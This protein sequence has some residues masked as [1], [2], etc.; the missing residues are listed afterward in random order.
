MA[1][2]KVTDTLWGST[3]AVQRRKAL[4][5]HLCQRPVSQGGLGLALVKTKYD[6][7]QALRLA[8]W[9]HS[10]QEEAEQ[11][12]RKIWARWVLRFSKHGDA[13]PQLSGAVRVWAQLSGRKAEQVWQDL[14]QVV[15]QGVDAQLQ[16]T[17]IKGGTEPST[18]YTA[19]A[20]RWA[21]TRKVGQAALKES[22]RK[23]RE[24]LGDRSLE[25]TSALWMSIWKAP[26]PRQL[27]SLLRV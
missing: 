24:D 20:G 6:S 22:E 23:L 21:L 27:L 19:S 15:V 3:A 17:N 26:L 14:Q 25:L 13:P 2:S 10:A 18:S 9:M 5:I 16:F 11:P 4:A 1:Q 7:L 12:W 8:W